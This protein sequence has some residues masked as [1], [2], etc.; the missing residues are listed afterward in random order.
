MSNKSIEICKL[1]TKW[2]FSDY[3]SVSDNFNV[4]KWKAHL[5]SISKVKHMWG[6]FV[7]IN[8]IFFLTWYLDKRN[9][10]TLPTYLYE[11]LG[12]K[13]IEQLVNHSFL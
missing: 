6:C 13:S 9:I 8:S 7:F 2:S 11:R 10:N 1:T 3:L 12:S 4:Q 5:F